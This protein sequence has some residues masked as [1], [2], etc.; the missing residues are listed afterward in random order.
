MICGGE[1]IRRQGS[2]LD[3]EVFEGT[4]LDRGD[5]RVDPELRERP[6][7]ALELLL[8][9]VEASSSSQPL[10][11]KA[12]DVEALLRKRGDYRPH[13]DFGVN[14]SIPWNAGSK[15][16]PSWDVGVGSAYHNTRALEDRLQS[17]REAAERPLTAAPEGDANAQVLCES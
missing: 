10:D 13:Q 8:E 15:E 11:V 3:T 9:R 1:V 7:L 12:D 6:R 16:E 14:L 17:T 2:D 5:I 4:P